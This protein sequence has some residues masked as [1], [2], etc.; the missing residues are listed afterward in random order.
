V[1]VI[2]ADGMRKNEAGKAPS[3]AVVLR[4]NISQGESI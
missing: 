3:A 2:K 1:K 4:I